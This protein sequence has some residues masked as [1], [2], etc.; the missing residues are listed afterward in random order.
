MDKDVR[1]AEALRLVQAFYRID[2]PEDR[3]LMIAI[4]EATAGGGRTGLM[5]VVAGLN[6]P[7]APPLRT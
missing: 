2:D 6:D 1:A 7:K 5:T 3:K 4:I